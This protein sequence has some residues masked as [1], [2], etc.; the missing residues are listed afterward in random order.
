MNAVAVHEAPLVRQDSIAPLK[1]Q[2][3]V[4]SVSHLADDINAFEFVSVDS[5]TLPAFTPGSHIDVHLPNG[6]IRQYSLCNPST[7]R[8]RYV[9][10]VLRDP[11]GR[12]GSVAMH[13]VLRAGQVVTVSAPRNHFALSN[14]AT[15]HIFIAG[16]IGITP[17]MSMIAEVALTQDFCYRAAAVASCS[18]LPVRMLAGT[19]YDEAA[20]HDNT[21]GIDRGGR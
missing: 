11:L 12:G 8:H 6:A 10:A 16:G 21:T 9:I 5:D 20:Q 1:L 7:E 13:D 2:V 19:T 18:F 14:S 4:Q 15:R 3:R 17:L